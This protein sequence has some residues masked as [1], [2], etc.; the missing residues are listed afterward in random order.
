VKD[1][2]LN[3]TDSSED[4]TTGAFERFERLTRQLVRVPK[5]EIDKQRKKAERAKARRARGS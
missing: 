4:D 5:T 1:Q 2:S 3:G